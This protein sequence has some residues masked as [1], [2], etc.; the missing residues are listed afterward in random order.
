MAKSIQINIYYIYLSTRK[1]GKQLFH[2][3]ISPPFLSFGGLD[4]GSEVLGANPR[5]P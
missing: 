2:I 5:E 3:N 1:G 4:P